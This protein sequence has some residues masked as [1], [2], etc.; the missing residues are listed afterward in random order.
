MEDTFRK[1]AG[2]EHV[3]AIKW[4][5]P[6]S[7]EYKEME[8]L[9]P[10]FNILENG[11]NIGECFRLGGNGFLDEQATAYPQHELAILAL[12]GR[13]NSTRGR[14]CGT[15]SLSPFAPSTRR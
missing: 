3:V 13:E 15:Q 1:M 14:R 4:C 5:Q 11:S 12:V 10:H 7:Y 6:R 8:A 9:A 2:F